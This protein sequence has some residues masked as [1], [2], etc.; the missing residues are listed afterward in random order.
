MGLLNRNASRP[1]ARE[2]GRMR[3][4]LRE[5]DE[6]REETLRDIGGLALE[7]HKRDRLEPRL[8][9]ERAAAV[10]ALDQEADGLREALEKGASAAQPANP[11]EERSK[12]GGAPESHPR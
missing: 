1:G 10:A 8:L 5:I 7:M 3:R 2:R 11:A 4:R 9:T 6:E 12:L